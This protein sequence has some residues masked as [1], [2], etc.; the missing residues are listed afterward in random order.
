MA[1]LW[2]VASAPA[3]LGQAT[4]AGERQEKRCGSKRLHGERL[5]I[6]VVGKPISCAKARRIV[7]G[8]ECDFNRPWVCLGLRWPDPILVWQRLKEVV[9]DVPSTAIEGRRD[10][11]PCDELSI[12]R[13]D[14]RR[15]DALEGW[16]TSRQML[17]DDLLRCDA[18]IGKARRQLKGLLGR[19]QWGGHRH[20]GWVLGDE[21]HLFRIDP[22]LLYVSYSHRGIARS[23]EI[24]QG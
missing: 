24:V 3:A 21:R 19:P 12:T 16:P 7:A 20:N 17:A 18:L 14:W 6:W 8:T 9:K 2:F 22:E 11:I 10:L 5:S 1:A 15:T 23:A 13:R 4:S